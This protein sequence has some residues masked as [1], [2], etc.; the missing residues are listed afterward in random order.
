MTGAASYDDLVRGARALAP[1]LRERAAAAEALRRLPDATIADLRAAGLFKAFR[2]ARYGGIEAPFRGFI[3]LGAALA[4][5]CG[6][7]S[8]VYN[9]LVSHNWMLGYWPAAAQDEVWSDDREALIGSGLVMT[10]GAVRPVADGWRLSGRWP[11]SSGV[12]A[13]AWLMLGTRFASEAG[14]AAPHLL[15]VPRADCRVEDTW[16]VMG[17]AATGSK[18]VVLDDVFVPSH[19]A[20]ATAV[21][22]GGPHPGSAVNPGPLYRLTWLPLFSF[23]PAGT[24]LGIAQGAVADYAAAT[25]SRIATYS[26]KALAE[27]A[28][29]QMR[30]AE[31]ATLVDAAETILLKGCDEAT[32]LAGGGGL[33]ALAD[34]A[35][36]RRDGAYA[37]Q[38]AARAVDI[39]FAGT[40]G[41]A[42][43]ETH[44]LQRALRDVHAANGHAGVNWDLNGGLYGR[45]ALGLAPD[46]PL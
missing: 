26:G 36:W 9:N 43:L 15:L 40:G 20:V 4:A 30:L 16:H 44:P 1:V 11:Y 42:I 25:R 34:R 14:A 41:G 35:R 37:A 10:A 6:S 21:G 18:D 22:Q 29:T 5:G 23:V 7:T 31:A 2:P 3:E 38:L 33:P 12:D 17:L 27:L 46:L 39:V 13:A 8:W 32:A 45:V 19:R 24:S 28:T